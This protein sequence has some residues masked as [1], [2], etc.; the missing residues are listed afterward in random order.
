MP[1]FVRT[2]VGSCV[3]LSEFDAHLVGLTVTFSHFRKAPYQVLPIFGNVVVVP[4][5]RDVCLLV[6]HHVPRRKSARYDLSAN[7]H[8]SQGVSLS[9]GN[10]SQHSPE[11]VQTTFEHAAYLGPSS[12][13]TPTLNLFAP[14]FV[15][16]VS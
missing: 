16:R 10:A 12:S 15:H 2:F 6:R 3:S 9:P 13:L 7:E 4:V 11:S 14:F 8:K 1:V 5:V